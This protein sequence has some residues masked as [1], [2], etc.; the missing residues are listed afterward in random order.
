MSFRAEFQQSTYFFMCKY[1][2][3]VT[4]GRTG[5]NHTKSITEF[6]SGKRGNIGEDFSFVLY[7][8]QFLP[9]AHTWRITNVDCF[10][11]Y[12][13]PPTSKGQLSG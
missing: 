4:R 13:P 7:V 6:S 3:I 8:P 2:H 11:S 9:V 12:Q 5:Q 1:M 10:S